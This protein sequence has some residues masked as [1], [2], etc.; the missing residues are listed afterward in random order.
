M[1]VNAIIDSAMLQGAMNESPQRFELKYIAPKHHASVAFTRIK[2]HVH[3]SV[4]RR[5]PSA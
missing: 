3:L 4:E 2:L 5:I 1:I